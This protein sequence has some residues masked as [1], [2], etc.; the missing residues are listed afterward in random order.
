MK[1]A[2]FG[3]YYMTDS[4][5]DVSFPIGYT[6]FCFFFFKIYAAFL[7]VNEGYFSPISVLLCVLHSRVKYMS[8]EVLAQGRVKVTS[9][10]REY[11]TGWKEIRQLSH[12]P[13]GCKADVWSLGILLLEAHL[14]GRSQMQ[15]PRFQSHGAQRM[16][17]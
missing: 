2:N 11:S 13:S 4:G 7:L 3:M 1:L 6:I 9:V 5:A 10:D 8:P 14:V 15:I 16:W 17:L 12:T